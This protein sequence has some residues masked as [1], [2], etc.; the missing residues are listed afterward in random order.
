M[1][2]ITI[3]RS[4]PTIVELNDAYFFRHS[5][6]ELN[7]GSDMV[8]AR[9]AIAVVPRATYDTLVAGLIHTRYS[10]DAETAILANYLADPNNEAHKAEF[11]EYQAWRAQVKSACKEYF[12]N[13]NK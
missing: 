10:P 11:D 4:S 5:H 2:T 9:E 6:T 3:N 12:D 7:D 1:R 13:L 8:E